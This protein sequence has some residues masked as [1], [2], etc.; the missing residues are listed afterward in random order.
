MIYRMRQL[1]HISWILFWLCAP[2]PTNGQPATQ[3]ATT[4]PSPVRY[5]A[6]DG[7]CTIDVSLDWRISNSAPSPNEIL[8]LVTRDNPLGILGIQAAAGHL[9][10]DKVVENAKEDAS[11]LPGDQATVHSSK[12]V[13][14]GADAIELVCYMQAAGIVF[15]EKSIVVNHDGKAFVLHFFAEPKYWGKREAEFDR[16]L[17]SFKFAKIMPAARR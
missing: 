1:K 7:S 15:R 17:Q 5:V 13:V 2:T 6:T 14:D 16:I 10:Y 9:P 4:R 8:G 11:K 3:P 12:I